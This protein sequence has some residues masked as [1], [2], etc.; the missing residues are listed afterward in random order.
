MIQS[1]VRVSL[2]FAA[3]ILVSMLARSPG[4]L[5]PVAILPWASALLVTWKVTITILWLKRTR[6]LYFLQTA[7]LPRGSLAA[8]RRMHRRHRRL[9]WTHSMFD[10]AIVFVAAF[11]RPRLRLPRRR[12]PA[13]QPPS[14]SPLD[15]RAHSLSCSRCRIA[16]KNLEAEAEVRRAVW[17]GPDQAAAF[18]RHAK[19]TW[20][21]RDNLGYAWKVLE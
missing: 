16:S 19:I 8:G 12:Q 15:R 6:S 3:L 11:P 5:R 9:V 1:V 13:S 10:R 18:S 21:N 17:P 4:G 7:R 2:F 14:L 20:K